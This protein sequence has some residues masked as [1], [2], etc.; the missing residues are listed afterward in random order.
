MIRIRSLFLL[1]TWLALGNNC[2]LPAEEPQPAASAPALPNAAGIYWHAFAAFPSLNDEER[3]L[4]RTASPTA[5]ATLPD[6]LAAIVNRFSRALHELHRARAVVPCDW[7]LDLAAGPDLI[8]P[9]VDKTLELSRVALL[10][11]RQRFAM[12]ET[13]AALK[14]VLAVFKLARDCGSSPLVITMLVNAS[15]EK[16]ATEV[17]A[18][19]VTHLNAD[20]LRQCATDLQNLPASSDLASTILIDQSMI[21]DWW[22]RELNKELARLNDPNAVGQAF[23]NIAAPLNARG[24]PGPTEEE[25]AEEKRKTALLKSLTVLEVQQVFQQMRAHYAEIHTIAKLPLA[26]RAARVESADRS[27]SLEKR[28]TAENK[29]ETRDDAMQYI[30]TIMLSFDWRDIFSR[31]EQMHARRHLLDQALR[32]QMDGAHAVQEFQGRKIEYRKTTTGFELS[33]PLRG[34]LEVLTVG[35]S[36]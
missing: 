18:A 32:I 34:K 22:E 35:A 6:D 28:F 19:H 21:C 29:L 36:K 20:Q 31:E 23:V 4:V 17:L 24:G 33:C 26:Q 13:D 10:R 25:V 14:D 3:K 9:H 7:Q 16:S 27:K 2:S 5:M 8:L 12:G 11:A 1:C 15:I 30:A